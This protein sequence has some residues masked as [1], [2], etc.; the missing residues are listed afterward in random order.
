M[1]SI[2]QSLFT[3]HEDKHVCCTCVAVGAVGV[4]VVVIV[5][6]LGGEHHA[7][8]V[9][10][11]VRQISRQGR[12]VNGVVALR[13]IEIKSVFDEAPAL[14]PVFQLDVKDRVALSGEGVDLPETQ[15]KLPCER[16]VV[17]GSDTI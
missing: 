3:S 15:P 11:G 7:C 14:F 1:T 6:V 5:P 10:H 16:D 9:A 8:L 4:L 17:E 12:E 13:T 2:H